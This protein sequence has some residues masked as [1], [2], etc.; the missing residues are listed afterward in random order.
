MDCKHVQNMI[1]SYINDE[2]S[3]YEVMT[4]LDHINHCDECYDE[5]EITYIATVGLQRLDDDDADYDLRG[6]MQ[7]SLK[8][9]ADYIKL[10][11]RLKV[12]RYACSTLAVYGVFVTAFL[13]IRMLFF[14]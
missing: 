7:K 3:D 13:L 10:M 8:E 11:T 4:F 1:P 9:S 12:C 14:S 2:L 6:A 5:L